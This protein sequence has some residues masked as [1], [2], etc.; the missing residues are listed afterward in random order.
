MDKKNNIES[1]D[2]PAENIQQDFKLEDFM[3]LKQERDE[4]EMKNREL[5]DANKELVNLSQRLKADYENMQKRN[6]KEREEYKKYS[7]VELIS[8]SLYFLDNFDRALG[9][10]IKPENTEEF[11]SGFRMMRE[12]FFNTLGKFGVSQVK[13]LHQEFNPD[14]H[15]AMMFEEDK[16]Y[17]CTL[18]IDEFEKGYLLY[19]R[20]I[21][22]A[23]VKVGRPPAEKT[24]NDK[25]VLDID[26]PEKSE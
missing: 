5:Q 21:R 26:K 14:I 10:E 12:Q 8:E 11:V 2:N 17:S 6:I 23:R 25:N 13:S 15:E 9:T 3:L 20:I 19:D 24:E 18:V 4:L 7:A 16:K 22:P 1:S